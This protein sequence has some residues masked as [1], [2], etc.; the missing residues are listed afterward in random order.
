MGMCRGASSVARYM[1]LLAGVAFPQPELAA[2]QPGQASPSAPGDREEVAGVR[3]EVTGEPCD[4]ELWAVD[5]EG[6]RREIVSLAKRRLRIARDVL[7]DPDMPN[8]LF[9]CLDIEAQGVDLDGDRLPDTLV[10]AR[11]NGGRSPLRH[12]RVSWR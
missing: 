6:K 5:K 7:R 9:E 1:A 3:F 10:G 11:R 4:V 2:A 12:G 8:E